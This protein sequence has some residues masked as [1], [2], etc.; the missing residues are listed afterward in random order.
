MVE[1]NVPEKGRCDGF[2]FI[3]PRSSPPHTSLER[4]RGGRKQCDGDVHGEKEGSII[5]IPAILCLTNV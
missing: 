3:S 4:P 2:L 1:L 5:A